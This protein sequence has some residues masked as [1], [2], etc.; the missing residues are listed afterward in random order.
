[1][2]KFYIGED[3]QNARKSLRKEVELARKESPYSLYVRFDETS[4]DSGNALD[5]FSG[6]GMFNPWNILIFEDISE[7]EDGES[8]YES[9]LPQFID[10]E[11][12]VFIQEKKLNKKIFDKFKDKATILDFAPPKKKEIIQNNFAIADAIGAKDKKNIWVEFEKARRSGRAMEEVH[13]TIFWAFKSLYICRTMEREEALASGMKEYTFRTYKN[14]SKNYL[15]DDLKR[16]LTELKEMYHD[17]HRGDGDL[18]LALE[19][20]LLGL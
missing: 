5:A 1:M 8:F 19:R 17:A 14:Y 9:I 4:Y 20:M 12:R 7:H 18:G 16:I 3:T 13:G 15:V 10:T 11:H 2:I 6:G